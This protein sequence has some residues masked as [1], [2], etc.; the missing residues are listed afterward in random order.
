MQVVGGTYA[1]TSGSSLGTTLMVKLQKADGSPPTTDVVIRVLGPNGWNNNAPLDTTYP[2]NDGFAWFTRPTIVPVTG[3]Y[4]AKAKLDGTEI[5]AEFSL[6]ASSLLA[7]ATDF[8]IAVPSTRQLKA[9]WRPVQGAQSY[10][11]RVVELDS[12]TV[13]KESRTGRSTPTIQ[14]KDVPFDIQHPHALITLASTAD[15]T[16][17]EP[18]FPEAFNVSVVQN[19]LSLS[20]A[21]D[22]SFGT[23][24]VST[25]YFSSYT[26]GYSR[27]LIQPDN[28]IVVAGYTSGATGGSQLLI[29]RYNP[30]GTLDTG[31][32]VEGFVTTAFTNTPAGDQ[33]PIGLTLHQGKILI[34]GASGPNTA[35][36]KVGLLRLNND[37]SPDTSFGTGGAVLA[38]PAGQ[39]LAQVTSLTILPD[40]RIVVGGSIKS[41]NEESF[42]LLAFLPSGAVDSSFGSSGVAS[43]PLPQTNEWVTDLAV[44]DDKIWA[45]GAIRRYN[46]W[47]H[48]ILARYNLDGSLDTSF[49]SGG[50][51]E[52]PPRATD[53]VAR[54]I[55]FRPDSKIAIITRVYGGDGGYGIRQFNADGNPDSS[56]GISSLALATTSGYEDV[57]SGLLRSDGKIILAGYSR[58]SEN[59][60]RWSLVQF[61]AE[62]KLDAS[63]GS[64]GIVR[65]TPFSG[66]AADI[67]A[68]N[69]RLLVV[70]WTQSISLQSGVAV[71]RF[72]P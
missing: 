68:N 37:G 30:D 55:L 49:G 46:S 31:F 35:S 24:G 17:T 43:L 8:E 60:L 66:S 47:G 25:R 52:T 34:A 27:V 5:S 26:N 16:S 20:G 1:S 29:S 4:Q 54:K 21:L 32:G 56:F 57:Q 11:S 36:F 9:S 22:A 39:N 15:L 61:T 59:N 28:K 33:Y 41:I 10:I 14:M 19:P 23:D 13:L 12:Q 64:Q 72:V 18:I 3:K 44:K 51:R 48:I 45:V 50:Y 67:V 6:N 70:G 62:G 63:F 7:Q 2:A 40:E 53:E 38:S 58:D 65:I 69:G 42:L 71:A